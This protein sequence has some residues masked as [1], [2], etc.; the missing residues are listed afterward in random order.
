LGLSSQEVLD[1]RFLAVE[2]ASEDWGGAWLSKGFRSMLKS[3]DSPHLISSLGDARLAKAGS[4]DVLAGLCAGFMAQG[5]PPLRAA[6]L[7]TLVQALTA[8]FFDGDSL[9][10]LPSDQIRLVPKVLKFLRKKAS[11]RLP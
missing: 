9:S 5:L 6:A 4:G 3:P 11:Y 8:N 7:A 10:F 2:K 1:N